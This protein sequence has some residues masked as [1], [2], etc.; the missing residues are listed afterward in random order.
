M[1]MYPLQY[2]YI[3]GSKVFAMVFLQLCKVGDVWLQAS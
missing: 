2:V 1:L 3:F